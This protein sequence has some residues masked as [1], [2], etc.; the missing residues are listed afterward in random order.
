MNSHPITLSAAGALALAAALLAGVCV[1]FWVAIP[2]P[3][4]SRQTT[5]AEMRREIVTLEKQ[6]SR[7]GELDRW[8]TAREEALTLRSD[9]LLKKGGASSS[10]LIQGL[11]RK[12]ANDSGLSVVSAQ[13]YAPG[14]PGAL[15]AGV[16]M[17]VSGDLNAVTVFL[18]DLSETKPRLFVE[19]VVIRPQAGE[20]G[21]AEFS[22][23]VT[24]VAFYWSEEAM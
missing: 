8:T 13:D 2:S 20:G 11:M 17:N 4:L 24:A 21:G 12:A 14:D 18:M 16:R 10:A 6:R 9:F 19:D 22:V 5:I 7:L 3:L 15:P 23:T 1:L